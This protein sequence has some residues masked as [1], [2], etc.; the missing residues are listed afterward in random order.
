MAHLVEPANL[1]TF[2]SLIHTQIE[3]YEIRIR[4]HTDMNVQQTERIRPYFTVLHGAVLR[5]YFSVS[6]TNIYSL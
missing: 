3:G 6:C 1:L 2:P 5:S 4:Q